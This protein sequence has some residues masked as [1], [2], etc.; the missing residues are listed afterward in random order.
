[1]RVSRL[2][3]K[4][5]AL[6]GLLHD[7]AEAY[8]SDVPRPVKASLPA[9]VEMEARLLREIAEVFGLVWPMPPAVRWADD[10]LLAT[11]ARDLVAPPPASWGLTERPLEDLIV[12]LGPEAAERA[13]LDR[14]DALRSPRPT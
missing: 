14:F 5:L 10:V 9:F 3:D 1:V 8:L 6:W 4:D 12:P 2:L 7:A 11:E 13:F